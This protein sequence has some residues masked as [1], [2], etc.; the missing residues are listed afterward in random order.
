MAFKAGEVVAITVVAEWAE[1]VGAGHHLHEFKAEAGTA[2]TFAAEVVSMTD[3]EGLWVSSGDNEK[4]D[5]ITI[6][7]IPWGYILLVKS[8][9]QHGRI[10][11]G[12]TA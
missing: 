12:F 11:A 5:A 9:P 7:M 6:L 4:D 3:S 8:S 10:A 1:Q 2:P